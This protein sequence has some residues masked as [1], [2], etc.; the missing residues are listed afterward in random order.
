MKKKLLFLLALATMCA[1][2]SAAEW[3]QPIP[4]HQ[5]I[6]FG[7]TVY[8]YNRDAKG[9]FVGGNAYNTHGSIGPKGYKCILEETADGITISNM[10]EDKDN[11]MF[12]VFCENQVHEPYVDFNNNGDIYWNFVD[13]GDGSYLLYN[14]C[15]TNA[16]MPLGVDT[17]KDNLTLLLFTDP[18]FKEANYINWQFVS[19]EAYAKYFAAAEIYSAA[20]T[21]G[22]KID[23]ATNLGV[24]EEA[25]NAAK[26]VYDNTSSTLDELNQAGKTLQGFI[27]DFKEHAATPDEPQNLTDKYIPDADFE[28][29]QGAGVWQRTHS[30][31]NYQTSGTAGKLGDET[32]FLEAWNGSAFSGKQYVQIT[33]LPNG[34]YQFFLSA[35]TNG[36]NGSYIYAGT[37]SVEVTSGEMKEYFVFTRV[38][39]G[40]LE[41]GFDMPKAIQNWVGIDNAKLLYLGNTVPSYAYWVEKNIEKSINP[42]EEDIFAQTS[43]VNTFSGLRNTDLSKFTTVDEILAFSEQFDATLASLKANIAAYKTFY[44][45]YV[46]IN[47]LQT[48]GY[49]GDAADELYDSYQEGE[50]YEIF[51]SKNLSTEEMLAKCEEISKAVENVKK[52]CLAPGMTC[53]NLLVNPNFTNRVEGWNHDT[54]LGDPAWG[55]LSSNPNV[56]RWNDNFDFYQ[57]VNGV[58]NGVYELTVQAFYRPTGDTKTSYDNFNS[59]TKDDILA[60]IYVNSSEAPI[61]NIAEHTYTENLENNCTQVSTDPAL[62]CPNGMNSA[63]VAFSKGDYVNKVKGVVVDGVLKVGIKSQGSIEGRWT[64][65]DNFTLKYIGKDFETVQNAIDEYE[66]ECNKYSNADMKITAALRKEVDTKYAAAKGATDGESAF[67]ALIEF[68]KTLDA[69]KE[70]EEAYNNLLSYNEKVANLIDEPLTDN[71]DVLETANRFYQDIEAGINDGTFTTEEAIAKIEE[72][73]AMC[74]KLRVPNYA[75]ASEDNAIPFT[76]VIENPSFEDKDGNASLDGWVNDGDLKMQ[77][78]TN[79]SFAKTGNVYCERWHASGKINLHQTVTELPNGYYKLTV[80]AFCEA[81][82]AIIFAGDKE[83]PFSNKTNS[84]NLTTEEIVVKVE[85]GTLDFGVRVNLTGSTWVC[86]DNFTLSYIGTEAPTTGVKAIADDANIDATASEFFS[87]SG[88]RTN[89]LQK[90]INIVKMTNGTVKKVIV[91]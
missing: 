68:V 30:A 1:G 70:S 19:K 49:Q 43:L 51:E 47:D 36:G 35:A 2:A 67:N 32:V 3:Q 88:T 62:Y 65:W 38:S 12:Y 7:D 90:G 53:T 20:T 82:D 22:G 77:T 31:Q 11:Q 83:I 6:S 81:E 87:V 37:D 74:A 27:N 44:D 24:N 86:V 72:A 41:V 64:L 60:Q 39:D 58:P 13:Q 79:T 14:N 40:N 8:L 17:S 25:I 33:D 73:K 71:K 9:F 42:E 54:S 4:E 69:A 26:A 66:D 91:K 45:L 5:A 75:G 23:E 10:V 56:E 50:I 78:Q 89:A 84:T 80:D 29:N 63:S 21:L 59:E 85:D 46:E 18:E 34:V 15:T 57:V 28:L 16:G 55:G 48:I 52:N 76:S 61:K